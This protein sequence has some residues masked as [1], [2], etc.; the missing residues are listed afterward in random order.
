MVFVVYGRDSLAKTALFGFLRDVGLRPLEWEQA[1]HLTETASPYIGDVL[2]AAFSHVQAVIV[3]L[4]P[5]DEARLRPG[6]VE[7]WDPEFETT[8]TGQPRP[9]VLFEAGMAFGRHPE[10]TLLVEMAAIR[11]FSDVTGRHV[12]RLTDS[13]SSK[14]ALVERLRRAGCDCDT[15]GQDW[16][17]GERFVMVGAQKLQSPVMNVKPPF[18]PSILVHSL[19]IVNPRSAY[20][21]IGSTLVVDETKTIGRGRLSASKKGLTVERQNQAGSFVI[22]VRE[23]LS[24]GRSTPF[25]PKA[26]SPSV[27]ARVLLVKL[28]ASVSSGSCGLKIATVSHFDRQILDY[29]FVQIDAGK[30][31]IRECLLTIPPES[32]AYFEIHQFGATELSTLKITSFEILQLSS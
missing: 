5:D 9:N 26:E 20:A 8:L 2:D 22:E 6:L 31:Q 19:A 27:N 24:D 30:S 29:R 3:M 25:I 11:P 13:A 21:G 18:S 16:L 1:V 12:I 4:T 23:F 32:A 7:D 15:E 17:R 14:H 28:K 10:R